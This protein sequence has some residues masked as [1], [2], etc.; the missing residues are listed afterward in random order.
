MCKI[1][2]GYRMKGGARVVLYRSTSWQ[3]KLMSLGMTWIV[4]LN[5]MATC[6]TAA[7]V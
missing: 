4:V 5:G 3:T 6:K 2:R 1:S 7:G